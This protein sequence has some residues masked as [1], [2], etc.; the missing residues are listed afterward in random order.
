MLRRLVALAATPLLAVPAA[1][2]ASGSAAEDP[3]A[4]QVV[5]AFYPL[6]FLAGRV[7]GEHVSVTGLTPPG[8][9]AHDLELSPSQVAEVSEAD[10]VVHLAGFQP[11]VDDAVTAYATGSS[12]DVATV[13]PALDHNDEQAEQAEPDDHADDHGDDDH[14]DDHG[15]ADPH[16]WLDP[17]RFATIAGA[18]A[19]RL[20][21]LDPDHAAAYRANADA[22]GADLATLDAE[23]AEGLASCERREIVVSHAAF[24]YLADRYDLEQI[25]VT[26]LSPED[27]PTPQQLAGAIDQAQAHGATTIFFE[28]LVSPAVAEVIADQVGAT[29][30][31]LDP[32]EGLAPGAD[33]DY[34]S[35][36]RS[37]LTAL[38]EALGCR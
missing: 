17:D 18:A 2:C 7:G 34:L 31:V 11:A 12:L 21:E 4:V 25:A 14:G 36:M 3:D 6:E 32:I 37:N 9:E 27:E 8:A 29:T 13:V 22:L 24:G 19:E 28:V 23:L 30:A 1:A 5:A 38:R 16:V 10:L 15:G 20:A 33:D 26:G 35:L